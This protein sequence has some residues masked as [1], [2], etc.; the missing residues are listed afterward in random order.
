M[1]KLYKWS[2]EK[3]RWVLK[4]YGVRNLILEYRNTLQKVET[5]HLSLLI[6]GLN[7]DHNFEE[8]ISHWRI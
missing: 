1:I 6:L 7:P 3:N 2:K 8:T 5:S 4:D